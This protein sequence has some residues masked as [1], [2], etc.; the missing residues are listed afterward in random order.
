MKTRHTGDQ[1]ACRR[2]PRVE[3]QVVVVA[4]H[5]ERAMVIE[6]DIEREAGYG[7]AAVWAWME[8]C[9]SLEG[10]TRASTYPNTLLT[11]RLVM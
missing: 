3:E 5:E 7:V 2:C 6:R 1:T 8:Q 10:I 4:R 9:K 11:R